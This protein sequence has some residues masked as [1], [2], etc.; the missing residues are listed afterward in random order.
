MQPVFDLNDVDVRFGP[1]QL[2]VKA[3]CGINLR[4]FP[5]ERVALVGSNGCGKSTLLR[6]LHR[7]ISPTA[8]RM[9]VAPTASQAM[10]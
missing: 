6:V 4:I 5:G 8:G 10:L 9:S 3:L 2:G 7:L 1:A